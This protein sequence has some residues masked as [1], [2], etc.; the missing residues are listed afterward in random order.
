[1]KISLSPL[2][3]LPRITSAR[4]TLRPVTLEDICEEYIDWL[5]DPDINSFLEIRHTKQTPELVRKYIKDHLEDTTYSKHFGIFLPQMN[6]L[7]IGTVTV[8]GINP[9]HKRGDISFVLGRKIAHG[10]GF[11]TEAVHCIC[12]YLFAIEN[13]HKVTGGHYAQHI[14]CAQVFDNNGFCHEATLKK[15]SLDSDNEWADVCLH[16]L[17][18]EDFVKQPNL[19]GDSG[20]L[21]IHHAKSSS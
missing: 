1:M 21:I 14:K 10:K 11:A 20:E 15:Y 2:G 7:F 5:N 9:I 6:D 16:G 17:L 3:A 18:T 19:L 13:F 12:A 8:N 4:L